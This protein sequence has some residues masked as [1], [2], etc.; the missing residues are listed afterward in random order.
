MLCSRVGRIR[1]LLIIEMKNWWR[2]VTLGGKR[3]HSDSAFMNPCN[4][5]NN[6]CQKRKPELPSW[7]IVIIEYY[8]TKC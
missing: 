4:P 3:D 1:G 7:M 8:S 5:R 6:R 2:V